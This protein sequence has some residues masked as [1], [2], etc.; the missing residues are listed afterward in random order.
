MSDYEI[1]G[2][3]LSSNLFQKSIGLYKDCYRRSIYIAGVF[4]KGNSITVA[5][6]I[7]CLKLPNNRCADELVYAFVRRYGLMKREKF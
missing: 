3:L 5:E 4:I 2:V 1:G 7:P 6:P